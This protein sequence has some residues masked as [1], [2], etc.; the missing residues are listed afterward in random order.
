MT[1]V[2]MSFSTLLSGD[3][4]GA[5]AYA[6]ENQAAAGYLITYTLL[7]YLAISLHMVSGYSCQLFI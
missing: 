7:A 5:F 6:R 3:L 2:L 1:L 4:L